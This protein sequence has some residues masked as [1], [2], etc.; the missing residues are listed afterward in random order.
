M[1]SF[2]IPMVI[3]EMSARHRRVRPTAASFGLR[4]WTANDGLGVI[5]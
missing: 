2:T 5:S 1:I 3:A 4:A